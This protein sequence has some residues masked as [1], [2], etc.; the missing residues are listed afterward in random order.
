[1]PRLPRMLHLTAMLVVI[2]SRHVACSVGP[3][4]QVFGSRVSQ[5]VGLAWFFRRLAGML[6]FSGVVQRS[7]QRP[8]SLIFVDESPNVAANSNLS[9]CGV[10]NKVRSAI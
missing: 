8:F 6:S 4:L 1:M 7:F 5:S 9:R 2:H 3:C 10:P